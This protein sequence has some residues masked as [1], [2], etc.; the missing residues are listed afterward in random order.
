MFEIGRIVALVTIILNILAIA[1]FSW[2]KKYLR[3]ES[4][5]KIASAVTVAIGGVFALY[6]IALSVLMIFAFTSKHYLFASMLIMPLVIPFII[7][8]I[9]TYEKAPMFINFQILT[10][11][12]SLILT[13]LIFV[14]TNADITTSNEIAK[15]SNQARKGILFYLKNDVTAKAKSLKF[16]LIHN[17]VLP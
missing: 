8:Y 12:F 1:G 10:F 3:R 7:S 6:I 13:S 15:A 17:Q 5:S 4:T 9:S 16:E 11:V 2:I 14:H